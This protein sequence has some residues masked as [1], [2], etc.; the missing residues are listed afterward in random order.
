MIQQV[1]FDEI[2]QNIEVKPFKTQLLKWVGNKQKFSNEIVSSFPMK[3]NRYFEPFLGSG[4]VLSTLSP[5]NAL[6]S[7][8]F[9]PLIDIFLNL[10]NNPEELK[11][12]Y[13]SRWE[14]AHG[15][16]KKEGYEKI[17]ASY[18]KNP[19]GADF[20]YLS[21]SCY[22]GVIRF[23]KSDGYMSTPCGAHEPIT[24]ESFNHRVDLWGERVIHTE[25]RSCG[26]QDAM[27]EAKAGD[28]VYCDPPYSHSQAI[29]Y[30]G[31]NFE[32]EE[33]LKEIE[34]CKSR[35]VFVALSID[36]TKKSGKLH[37]N[38]PIPDNLFEEEIFVNVGP[39]MLKRFQM[40]GKTLENEIVSDRL[41]LTYTL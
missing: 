14:V 18:N 31:H 12:W 37:C 24:P 8:A 11:E 22:G 2:H 41:L 26:Y 4:A 15:E 25:F 23:R 29:L 7:D 3:F 16:N 38:L 36:G 32:L 9:S 30:G 13:R 35:G 5:K 20:L 40:E 10:K 34:K 39:S 27:R 6:A 17:K 19:N 33:L 1:L 28:L 21:R